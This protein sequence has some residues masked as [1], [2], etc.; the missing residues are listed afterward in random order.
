MSK[1]MIDV[2]NGI[3]ASSS[4]DYQIY[5][6]VATRDNLSLVANP[7]LTYSIVKNEL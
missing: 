2:L 7:I 3:L 6:P 4:A 5:V 1:N